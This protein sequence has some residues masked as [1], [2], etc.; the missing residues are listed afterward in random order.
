MRL[1]QLAMHWEPDEALAMIQFLDQLKE[2]LW[3]AYGEEI[4]HREYTDQN[5]RNFHEEQLTLDFDDPVPF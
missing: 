1:T 4:V 2:L 5:H 3:F